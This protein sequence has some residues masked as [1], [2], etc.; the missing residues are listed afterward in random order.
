MAEAIMKKLLKEQKLEMIF[1][2]DS[3]ATSFEEV[4]NPIYPPAREKLKERGIL[5]FTH[6]AKVFKKENYDEYDYIIGMEESNIY[7][8]IRI[9]D[10]DQEHKIR[11]LLGHHD[12]KDP[13]YTRDFE[14]TYQEIEYGCR[15]L[16][17]E[18]I[19]REGE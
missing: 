13:W 3:M 6:Q 2:V 15:Q 11:K 18:L 10:A 8:L 14:T 17:E 5:A 16:L 12:I 4:G 19:K 9:V 7:N 1:Q